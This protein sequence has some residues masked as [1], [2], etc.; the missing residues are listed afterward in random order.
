MSH[1]MLLPMLKLKKKKK[2]QLVSFKNMFLPKAG[3]DNNSSIF[4]LLF[5]IQK[6]ASLAHSNIFNVP[7]PRELYSFSFNNF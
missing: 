4:H 3:F 6:K 2:I 7:K 1:L 5:E